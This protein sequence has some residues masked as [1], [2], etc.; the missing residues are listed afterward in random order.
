MGMGGSK[1]LEAEMKQREQQFQ[2]SQA[3]LQA[4]QTAQ[5]QAFMSQDAATRA[6]VANQMAAANGQTPE[7]QAAAKLS[8][9]DFIKT[10]PQGLLN[11]PKTGKLTLM[12][13]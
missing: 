12:G 10:S 3:S 5:M 4:S 2:A 8:V 9:M 1:K 11:E 13:N 7:A 6:A